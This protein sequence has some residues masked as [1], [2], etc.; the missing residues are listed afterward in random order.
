M[1][2]TYTSQFSYILFSVLSPRCV[3]WF[4]SFFLIFCLSCLCLSYLCL[5][6]LSR[7]CLS[8][9]CLSCP[10][11]SCLSRP[12]LSCLCLSYLCLSCPCP[13]SYTHLRA[14]ET[15][16]HLVCRLLLVKKQ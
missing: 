9:P 7:P 5:S 4:S 16:E 11:L 1:I 2:S 10:C 15:P 8:Y 14:H 3:R 13:V 12:C 6:C